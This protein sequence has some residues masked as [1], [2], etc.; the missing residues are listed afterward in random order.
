MASVQK[1]I[2]WSLQSRS[3]FRLVLSS[4]YYKEGLVH[5]VIRNEKE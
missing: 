1:F 4:W 2:S 5:M 3:V